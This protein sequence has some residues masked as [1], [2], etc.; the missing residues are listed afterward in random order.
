MDKEVYMNFCKSKIV[1]V[2]N[3]NSIAADYFEIYTFEKNAFKVSCN[4]VYNK[5]N[6]INEN[7]IR[8]INTMNYDKWFL[9][10]RKKKAMLHVKYIAI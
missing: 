8:V 1:I 3:R 10:K 6:D 5:L 7:E 4:D 9:K 2:E